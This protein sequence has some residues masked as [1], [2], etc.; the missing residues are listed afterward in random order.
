MKRL[1]A[2]LMIFA[3]M[4]C[5]ESTTS[6]D[7]PA[8]TKT[9]YTS[10][11][12]HLS[13]K[14]Y[15]DKVLGALVGS[16]IGDA[17]GASTEMWSRKD[18]Q[19]KYGYITTL[20]PAVRQQSPEG[21]WGHNLI[22]GATTDDTRWKYAMVK[23]LSQNKGDLNAPNFANFITDYYASLTKSINDN[24]TIPETDFL[25]TQI[26]KI[27]WI[28]EWAR[29][30]MAY[31]KDT[32]SYLK[33]MNRFYGGE[34][35]CAGQLYTPMFGLISNSPE[36]AYTLAY[37]HTLFDIGYAKD[38]SALVSAM[39]HMALRTKNIDSI[40]NT[41]TFVDP[42]RYQ[43]SRLVGRIAYDMTDASVKKVLALKQLVLADT[44]TPKDSIT[45]KIP[46]GFQ[47][48]HKDWT[49]QEMA[50][51]FLEKNEKA[52]PFHSGE[53]WQILV[54]ALQYGEGDFEKTLQFIVNYGRDNDT[55]AAVAGMILGAK[56][57]YSNLPVTL[58]TQALKV[59]KENMGI[60]LEALAREMVAKKHMEF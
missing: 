37:N 59:N 20:T 57:G 10:D 14:E 52:I 9:T 8:P 4:A 32:D 39:T 36:N 13:E 5:K 29:V 30:S 34:M 1:L 33:A 48:S 27:D 24:G 19:L 2:C 12:L 23:Y 17:M 21:T 46:E 28:K 31:E 26:E 42:L 25:D 11:T 54:T 60:D 53:I 7:I 51:Q 50:Y 45:F 44:L 15:Y 40:I 41:A 56:D 18:I 6:I 47:G 43:D 58:R 16:A 55:V 3:A 35:S 38:I 22:A 49:R